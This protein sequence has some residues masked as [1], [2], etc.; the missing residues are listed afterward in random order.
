MER[1]NIIRCSL[2]AFALVSIVLAMAVPAW[3]QGAMTADDQS[4]WDQGLGDTG[5]APEDMYMTIAVDGITGSTANFA[6][7][8]LSMKGTDDKAVLIK[9]GRHL[10]APITLPVTWDTFR[11]PTSCLQP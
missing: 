8:N 7:M 4:A 11:W 9:P 5:K 6:V 1:A 3:A 10:R 2:A